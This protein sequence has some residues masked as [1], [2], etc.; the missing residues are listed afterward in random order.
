[1]S[2]FHS[3]DRFDF[4]S[5]TNP[6]DAF[7][8]QWKS[9]MDFEEDVRDLL[10]LLR[11]NRAERVKGWRDYRTKG[12][13]YRVTVSWDP[14]LESLL[15]GPF[16]IPRMA[17]V[18]ESILVGSAREQDLLDPQAEFELYAGIVREL[19]ERL[20]EMRSRYE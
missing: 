13:G 6:R 11:P 8:S 12:D 7:L 15:Q 20:K 10:K 2:D 1:M 5:E 9:E 3:N 16:C 17:D 4:N 19:T 18:L 14:S